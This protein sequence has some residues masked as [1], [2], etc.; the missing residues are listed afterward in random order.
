MREY[1]IITQKE[2]KSSHLDGIFQKLLFYF[3][4]SGIYKRE[5]FF[6]LISFNGRRQPDGMKI[7]TLMAV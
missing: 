4:K 2:I 6:D 1:Q 3:H 5:E 7:P